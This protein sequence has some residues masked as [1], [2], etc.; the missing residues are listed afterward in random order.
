MPSEMPD[1]VPSPV[2]QASACANPQSISAATHSRK[3]ISAS[4]SPRPQRPPVIFSLPL[5]ALLPYFFNSFFI[6]YAGKES[7][8]L[9][10]HYIPSPPAAP[11]PFPAPPPNSPPPADRSTAPLPPE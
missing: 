6:R 1:H 4:S 5:T 11:A 3:P 8:P 7:H 9:L 2:A 10:A